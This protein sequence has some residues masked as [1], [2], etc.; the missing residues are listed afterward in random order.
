MCC[1]D[2][3]ASPGSKTMQLLEA[4]AAGSTSNGLVIANDAHPKRVHQLM[5]TIHRHSRPAAERA[6]F[7]VT[8]HRGE[9]FPMPY[10]PFVKQHEASESQ[11]GFDRVLCDVPCSGD[12][13]IRKDPTVRPRWTPA[14]GNQLHA[15]QLDIAWRG[16]EVLRVGGLMAYSTC[17]Y[18]PIEDEAV[19]SSLLARAH[20]ISP[21]AVVLETWPAH[22]LPSLVRHAGLST[23]GVA[24]HQERSSLAA[25]SCNDADWSDEEEEVRLR[26]HA[27][28]ASATAAG[29]THSVATMWPPSATQAK[30]MKLDR[31]SRLLPHDQ[32]TGGFFIALLRKTAR[33]GS[34]FASGA[35]GASLPEASMTHNEPAKTANGGAGSNDQK[36]KEGKPKMTKEMRKEFAKM[37]KKTQKKSV[38]QKSAGDMHEENMSALDFSKDAQ[39]AT[40]DTQDAP[41]ALSKDGP[42]SCR[43]LPLL[44]KDEM[45]VPLMGVGETEEIAQEFRIPLAMAK[46]RLLA[47]QDAQ[48]EDMEEE[49]SWAPAA[50]CAFRPGDL[51]LARAGLS[52][53]EASASGRLPSVKATTETVKKKRKKSDT[54]QGYGGEAPRSNTPTTTSTDVPTTQKTTSTSSGLKKVRR[55]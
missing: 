38:K 30:W 20:A 3:C 17:T 25:G 51:N 9:L 32:N 35:S 15:V 18:N 23:W 4:V 41:L 19:V 43:V 2:T 46:R 50:V 42:A 11:V 33:F 48:G 47:R 21:G 28:K 44:H 49:I 54:N 55:V 52:L 6:R 34:A 26:W 22:V 10:R 5:D 24:D 8:C 45:L 16:L 13:T 12:G 53:G 14:V 37:L 7:V 31:C 39:H 36:G 27:S 29:M 40:N 1:L